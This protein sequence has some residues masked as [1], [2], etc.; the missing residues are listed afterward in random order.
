MAYAEFRPNVKKVN[1]KPKGEVEI[2][3]TTDL[4]SLRGNI[5]RISE[6]IDQQ[7]HIAMDSTVVTY[8]VQINARTEKPIKSYRVDEQG[9]VSEVKPE[10]DQLEMDLDVVKRK[11]PIEDVPEEISREVV[12]DFIRSGLAPRPEKDWYPIDYWVARLAEGETYLKLA[13]EAGISSGRIVDIIDEYRQTVAPLAAK[14]DE[15]RKNKAEQP[16]GETEYEEDH[17][18]PGDPHEVGDEDLD[19][20][21]EPDH[22]DEREDTEELEDLDK[23]AESEDELSDWER[24][25]LGDDPHAEGAPENLTEPV[26]I[27]SVILAERP[28]FEDIPYDF[29][30]LLERRKGGETWMQIAGTLGIAS[31]KLSA[32]WSKYK[33]RVAEHRGG[34]A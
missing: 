19:D 1:L 16:A 2:V 30:T 4:G 22:D 8:N 25:I 13:N 27:E 28:F 7:V 3:L 29:P 21:A 18:D 26:D 15:W 34:A 20:D 17:E 31:T 11:D 33:K 12:D 5:E 14:W 10:G 9:V 24:Q 23:K 6:M 32:A